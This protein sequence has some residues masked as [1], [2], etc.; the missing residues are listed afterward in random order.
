MI[1]LKRL[2]DWFLLVICNFIWATQFVLVK[3]V[4]EQMGPAFATFFPMTLATVL[5]IALIAW[6]R[7]HGSHADRF[8]RGRMPLK[9]IR[10]FA[11]IAIC[12]Q[13]VAQL[14]I[15]WGVG[16]SLAMN[17]A[18]LMLALPVCTAVWAYVFLGERMTRLRW[19]SF[20]LA[21]VG[22]GACSKASIDWEAVNLTSLQFL[23]GNV[24]IFLSVNGSAFYNTYSK[25]LLRRYNPLQ[26]WYFT[27]IGV[28]LFMF[29]LTLYVEPSGFINLPTYRL[30]VWVGLLMLAGFVYFLSMVIFLRV[31]S[32]LDATQAGLCNYLIPL[33]GVPIAVLVR[34]EPI[35][36]FMV[37]GGLLVLA[38]TI[39]I[40]VYE[41]HR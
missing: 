6:Q 36:K 12:G 24:M 32:R 13:V 38:S 31:L 3:I 39:L 34:H 14:F 30:E 9:D 35:T 23:S 25:R 10:D 16:W 8:P 21:I 7:S 40:T 29:P 19:F 2:W 11:L 26:V 5:L 37:I 20:A 15:T 17:G 28:F 41:E 18:V 22:V 27:L 1:S 33:F 4:Q